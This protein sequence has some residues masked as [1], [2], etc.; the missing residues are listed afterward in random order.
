MMNSIE[1]LIMTYYLDPRVV[2]QYSVIYELVRLFQFSSV[3]KIFTYNFEHFYEK[4]FFS[5]YMLQASPVVFTFYAFF[6]RD[7][8]VI[9]MT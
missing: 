2:A 1:S 9:N 3:F 5:K 4:D 6:V 8:R 7:Y